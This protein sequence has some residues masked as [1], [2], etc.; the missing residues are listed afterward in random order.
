MSFFKFVEEEFLESFFDSGC[1]RLGT[2]LDFKDTLSHTSGRADAQ[3]GQ[4]TVFR[5]EPGEFKLYEHKH[6]AL[7]SDVIELIN[8][9]GPAILHDT[10]IELTKTSSDAF[11]FCVSNQFNKD[12]F[13]KWN[14]E[15]EKTNTCYEIFD[16][17]AFIGEITKKISTSAFFYSCKNILYTEYPVPHTSEAYGK[18]PVFV[19]ELNYSWQCE[20]RMVWPPKSP[21][22]SLSPWIIHVP[23]AVK[24]CRPLAKLDNGNIL[25][26]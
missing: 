17:R 15:S 2:V 13:Q 19:K 7:L 22:C 10:S 14:N 21:S 4:H 1:L 25:K 12:V 26:L 9:D 6:E 16:P 23:E 8:C 24:Y 3:E 5:N 11:I 20:T 18:R